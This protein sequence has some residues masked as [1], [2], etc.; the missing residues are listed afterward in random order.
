MKNEGQMIRR[1]EMWEKQ[2]CSSNANQKQTKKT[3]E[4]KEIRFIV[5]HRNLVAS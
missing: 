2:R 3:G 1:I 4:D 5:H